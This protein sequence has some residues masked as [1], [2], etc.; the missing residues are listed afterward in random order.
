MPERLA[1]EETDGD[2]RTFSLDGGMSM[3]GLGFQRSCCER[4]D[5]RFEDDERGM[6]PR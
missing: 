6:R 2:E 3:P 4:G 1:N 5:G